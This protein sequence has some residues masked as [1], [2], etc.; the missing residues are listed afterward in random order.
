ML[1][2]AFGSVIDFITQIG[3]K[4][5][6][7]WISVIGLSL[8]L[9]TVIVS[10]LC[11]QFSLEIKT[12]RAVEK[13]N[14]YL[15]SNPFIND[16]N[17]VEFNKLMK[18]VPQSMRLAWQQFMVNRDKKPSEFFNENDCIEK[19][20]KASG[21]K[22]QLVVV[23]TGIICTALLS[24]VFSCGAISGTGIT[25]SQVLLE[26]ALLGFAELLVGESYIL[27]LN[28]RRNSSLSDLYYNFASFQKYLDRATTTLPEYIDYEILFTRKE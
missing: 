22:T 9:F 5:G 19:P 4:L 11:T 16:D 7:G 20:F 24:F 17:L 21:Y 23:R 2:D 10:F 28:A 14:L 6:L 12:A 3:S 15:E 18:R 25:M 8:T 1:L 27:F 26:S 13:I